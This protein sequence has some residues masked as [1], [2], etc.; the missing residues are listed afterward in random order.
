MANARET[1]VVIIPT[2]NERGN[3]ERLIPLLYEKVLPKLDHYEVHLLV[4]DDS[5]PDGTGAVVETLVKKFPGVHLLVNPEKKGLGYAYAKGMKYALNQLNADIVFEFDAD[6]SHD[7]KKIPLM[8]NKIEEGF[9]LVLGSRYMKGGSIPANWGWHRKFFSVFGNIVIR[10]VIGVLGIRDW[11]TGYRAIKARVVKDVIDDLDEE[12]F[13]GYAFQIGFLHKTVRKG[14]RVA[15]VPFHFKDRTHGKSKLGSEYIKNTLIYIFKV[16]IKEL[17]G[18]RLF[19]FGM[20]GVVGAIVQLS[21]LWLFQQ[22]LSGSASALTLETRYQ[23][24]YFLSTEM[25][26]ISNFIWSNVWT[27]ADRKLSAVQIPAKFIQFNMASA[28]SIGIQQVLAFFG[29]RFIGLYDLFTLP[30]INIPV[31]TGMMYAV[32]GILLGMFWNFFAYSK[33]IWRKKQVA[34]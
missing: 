13:M 9:D 30:V 1:V 33:I 34:V 2:Y 18:H 25:A 23:I 15:E 19:K 11:T 3:I 20:V 28:G 17:T 4:V 31:S 8:L 26:V 27:F 7:P 10:L 24:A 21:T 14:Y 29:A 5:S 22:W 12:K 16:R 6:L 32:V